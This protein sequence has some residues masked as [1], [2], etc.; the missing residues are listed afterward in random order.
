MED[1]D[2]LD[3][4]G[5]NLIENCER[6]AADHTASQTSV[7]IRI[8]M[9]IS[10]DSRKRIIDTLHK[11]KIQVFALVSLPFARLSEFARQRCD[12]QWQVGNGN[13]VYSELLCTPAARCSL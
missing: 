10:D 3:L 13:A 4:I 1:R 5:T 8:L 11:F 2:D 12:P 6:K 7:Q 9:W